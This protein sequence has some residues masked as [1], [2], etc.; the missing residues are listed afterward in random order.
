MIINSKPSDFTDADSEFI[1][2]ES[3]ISGFIDKNL[4][5]EGATCLVYQMQLQGLNVAVKRL[6][7]EYLNEPV[8]NA[9][10]RKEF[11]IGRQLKHDAL[12]LYRELQAG[13]DELYIVMDFIDGLTLHEFLSADEGKRYFKSPDN[14]RRFFYELVSAIGYLHRKSVIHC[15]IKAA[16]VMLRHSDRAVMLIDLDKAYCDTMTT[17]HGGSAGASDP[18]R[19]GEKPT[20][21]K[22]FAAIGKLLDYIESN[23][24]GFPKRRFRRF[25]KKCGNAAITSEKLLDNLRPHPSVMPWLA[26]LAISLCVISAIAFFIFRPS[27]KS[28]GN[29]TIEK[30]INLHDTLNTRPDEPHYEISDE[31]VEPLVF[32]DDSRSIAASK[33]ADNGQIVINDFDSRM[34]EFIKEAQENLEILSKGTSS[35]NQLMQ[36]L[37][38]TSD[39]YRNKY[40]ALRTEYK[41]LYAEADG[42]DV[43]MALARAAE[44]SK[45]SAM[46]QQITQAT[47]DTIMRRNPE[48]YR[49]E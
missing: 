28:P 14:V 22:D 48:A 35:D 20:V 29:E 26:A 30:T 2:N 15:D 46:L 5:G 11:E 31:G 44:K 34:T 41:S 17:T 37:Y 12:P 1:E 23:T 9:A 36:M 32:T 43:E 40:R 42:I 8:H 18:L 25:R 7:K 21:R 47:R 16:N 45:A 39:S 3:I 33:P 4:C 10:F 24:P 13:A 6:K 27:L 19:R 38:K 49:G